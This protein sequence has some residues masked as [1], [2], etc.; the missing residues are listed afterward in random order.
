MEH[1]QASRDPHPRLAALYRLTE[2]PPKLPVAVLGLILIGLMGV[3]DYWLVD[4]RV[5][6]PL[7]YLLP[8]LG[9]AWFLG[10]R[11]AAYATVLA[12]VV[13]F[14]V[15]QAFAGELPIRLLVHLLRAATFVGALLAARGIATL[16]LLV[17][18]YSHA[19]AWR[20]VLQPIRVGRR[21]VLLPT[22]LRESY[23]E[24]APAPS[25][26][27]VVLNPGMA[28]GSGAHPTTQMCLALLEKYLRPGDRVF[29]L[30][31]GSGVLS[32]AAA[33][34]GAGWVLAVDIDPEAE[35][36]TRQ[37][38]GLNDVADAVEFRRGSLE[39]AQ[40]ALARGPLPTAGRPASLPVIPGA[41]QPQF[42]L[43]LAN[44]LTTT[45]LEA[46]RDGL[47][48]TLVPGG[49]LILSGVRTDEAERLRSS[50]RT[51]GLTPIEERQMGEWVAF[52]AWPV[53]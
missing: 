10:R 14:A 48:R 51:A 30:G 26:V 19:E 13:N 47:G 41:D 39:V 40:A 11:A 8:I 25:D 53:R 34:L 4:R 28:F 15:S 32:V 1:R 49:T 22:H 45:L 20:S 2:R 3:V 24:H 44:I 17:E 29:D 27:P 21:I 18:Y 50:L 42:D 37:N 35:R 43:A 6:V 46:L 31:C 7:H 36:I 5:A 23:A 38:V 12:A 52:A 16:R 9:L 33:R